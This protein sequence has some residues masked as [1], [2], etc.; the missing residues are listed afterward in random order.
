MGKGKGPVSHWG[1]RVRGGNVFE[2]CRVN[3]N[4]IIAALKTGGAKLPRTKIFT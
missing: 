1:A 4:T 3:F 2:V